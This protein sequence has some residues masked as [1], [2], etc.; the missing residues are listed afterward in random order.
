MNDAMFTQVVVLAHAP[1]LVGKRNDLSHSLSPVVIYF[2]ARRNGPSRSAARRGGKT[3]SLLFIVAFA[4]AAGSV[5]LYFGD[6][7][8]DSGFAAVRRTRPCTKRLKGFS[9][10]A[11]SLDPYNGIRPSTEAPSRSISTSSV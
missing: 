11:F 6:V 9:S 7:F 3:F 2:F 10:A 1:L 8:A 5:A 4:G